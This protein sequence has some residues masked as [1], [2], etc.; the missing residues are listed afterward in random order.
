[1]I[2]RVNGRIADMLKTTR[3]ASSADL[4]EVFLTC[5]GNCISLIE[6]K[7]L[8][9]KTPLEVL[10]EWYQTDPECFRDRPGNLGRL[11]I[12]PF[13]DKALGGRAAKGERTP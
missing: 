9:H 7:A 1:M 12:C 4:E 6:Q 8:G 10:D 13:V 11:D 5:R 3:L 2:E